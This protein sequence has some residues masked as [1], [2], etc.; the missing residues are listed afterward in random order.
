MTHTEPAA[1]AQVI[2]GTY[3]AQLVRSFLARCRISM[4]LCAHRVAESVACPMARLA[5]SCSRD[6]TPIGSTALLHVAV[7]DGARLQ[8]L[9]LRTL[10][11]T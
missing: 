1:E 7:W 4:R 10:V 2:V 5:K 11:A 6:G 8:H 9:F 3:H